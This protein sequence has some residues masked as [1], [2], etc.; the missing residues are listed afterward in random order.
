MADKKKSIGKD[1]TVLKAL[2]QCSF[3]FHGQKR[4]TLT[5]GFGD[6]WFEGPEGGT[7]SLTIEADGFAPAKYASLDTSTDVNLGE[8]ALGRL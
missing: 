8:I 6:F 1:K 5:D 7:F 3:A 4:E 2:G